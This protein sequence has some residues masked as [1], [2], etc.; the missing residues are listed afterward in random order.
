[1]ER[2]LRELPRESWR[3]AARLIALRDAMMERQQSAEVIVAVSHTVK[4]QTEGAK[5][6]PIFD[7]R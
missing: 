5:P 6:D 7:E 1:M 2:K 4:D 3:S